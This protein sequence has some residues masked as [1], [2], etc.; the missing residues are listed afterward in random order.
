M[1]KALYFVYQWLIAAPIFI[2]I[3]LLTAA[4]TTISL[5]MGG[6]DFWAHWPARIWS[7]LV[8]MI[9]LVRVKVKGK[10]NIDQSKSYVFVANHQGAFDIWAIFGYLPHR[11][12]W[13]M[14]KELEHIFMVGYACK[15]SGHIFVDDS[16]IASVRETISEAEHSLGEGMSLVVFPEGS[17]SL[18]GKMIPFKR[19]AFMLAGEFR[20]PVVPVTID[21]SFKAMPRT[22]YNITPCTITMT[23]H[24][25]IY[26][27]ERGFNTRTLMAQ[28]RQEINSALPEADR[29]KE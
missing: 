4:V 28:C 22:T 27:G 3:T 25:P 21:G 18:D 29:D 5:S 19:G 15:K 26:P 6:S 7:K 14:K 24:K 10:E 16:N 20:R 9:A 2:V 13:L 23:I 11:F 8:C 1:K 12:K 17:R